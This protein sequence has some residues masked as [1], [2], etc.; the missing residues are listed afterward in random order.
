MQPPTTL[1]LRTHKLGSTIAEEA[2]KSVKGLEENAIQSKY[3]ELVK[4]EETTGGQLAKCI[5]VVCRI[6]TNGTRSCQRKAKVG[7]G[8]G[9]RCVL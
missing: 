7:E 6:K 3:I 5:L 1:S 2:Q 4:A 8:Q 9:R